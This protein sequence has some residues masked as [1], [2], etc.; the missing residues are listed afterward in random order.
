MIGGRLAA[1]S[2]AALAACSEPPDNSIA[3]HPRADD[4]PFSAAVRVG[5]TVYLSGQLGIAPDGQSVVPGG[6][7]PEARRTM[8]LIGEDLKRLGLGYDDLV[9][10][11]VF[12]ADM[13]DW[14]AFNRV[15]A[16]YF[17][18]GRYPARSA[19]GA[20]ELALGARVELEC[21]AWAG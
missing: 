21:V 5:Q 13:A 19:L 8:E 6:L 7:E 20:N 3:F 12:L 16:G 9:K 18:P 14:P 17:K 4:R 11:T 10:C 15:Y 2:L 1:L